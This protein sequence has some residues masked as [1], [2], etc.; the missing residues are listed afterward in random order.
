M[1]NANLPKE[2]ASKG[3]EQ[4]NEDGRDCRT[5][6]A[7]WRSQHDRHDEIVCGVE[8]EMVRRIYK[9]GDD[10]EQWKS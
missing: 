6:R 7:L 4:S 9:S 3:D 2:H 5:H 1:E 10:G 8:N